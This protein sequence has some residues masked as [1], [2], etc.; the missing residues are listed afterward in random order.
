MREPFQLMSRS[1]EQMTL[2]PNI[3]LTNQNPPY[4]KVVL[5]PALVMLEVRG[6]PNPF[7]GKCKLIGCSQ[8]FATSGLPCAW[9]LQ[10]IL[11]VM[12]EGEVSADKA[13]G[14]QG[15]DPK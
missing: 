6:D 4:T 7:E 9:S 13:D 2:R 1:I 15:A 11:P 14:L 8:L 3:F 10:F 5:R 12:I